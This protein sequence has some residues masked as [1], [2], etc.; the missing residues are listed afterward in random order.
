ME[1][2][3]VVIG[4]DMETK[5]FD[6]QIKATEEKL[7]S[8][9][10]EYKVLE[11]AEP[12]EGQDKALLDLQKEIEKTRNNLVDL[13][14]KQDKIDQQG[15]ANTRQSL[16]NIGNSIQKITKKITKW[17][18]AIFGI[19]SA[20]MF[21]RQS[22]GT[23]SQ[24]DD[25][26]AADVEYIRY[27]LAT[28][29]KPIIEWI[30]KGVYEILKGINYLSIAWFNYNLFQNASV[31]N[32]KKM[33]KS[34]K[35]LQKTVSSF[36]EINIL[37]GNNDTNITMPSADLSKELGMEGYKAPPW[38]E[39]IANNGEKVAA[40]AALIIGSKLLGTGLAGIASL[41][42][43]IGGSIIG[44]NLVYTALTGRDLIKDL[45]DI[46]QGIKDI[47]KS[48]EEFAKMSDEV[49]KKT[50]VALQDRRKEAEAYQLNSKEVAQYE[51]S[52][53]A[54]VDT[55][56][57]EIGTNAEFR[58]EL[59]EVL[60]SYQKLYER[61]QLNEKQIAHYADL[62]EQAGGGASDFSKQVR[63]S[64]STGQYDASFSQFANWWN[65]NIG[66]L[67]K[68]IT[69]K[70]NYSS[71][72]GGFGAYGGGS[73]GGGFRAKGGIFY[74]S[75]LPK[76]AVGGIINM[77][78]PGIPYHGAYIG[79]R[80][81]EAVVPLTDSQQMELL[82]ETIGRY[83]TVNLTNITKLDSRQIARKVDKVQQNNSFVFN[84]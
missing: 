9:I 73:G 84:R 24:Y 43:L 41:G 75:K 62:L 15:F 78:G 72:G 55:R 40:A 80:G 82:G 51:A 58:E 70:L 36:D 77:P 60:I 6:L 71:A 39:W 67:D 42:A 21:I 5:G 17:G 48:Q 8:L 30:I 28:A 10:E 32:F 1:D 31:K 3:K 65:R 12:F 64:L 57:D 74:P 59:R 53:R 37:G 63:Q 61:G 54:L 46:C 22:M 23:L 81:A 29:I 49:H 79:E 66:K 35:E 7:E 19:R 44:V 25:K 38:L 20:Y 11:K 83:I 45:Y 33:N 76:L 69:I 2:G 68:E 13:K 56:M 16:D 14:E 18:L 52:L 50:L 26:L 47:K 4:I 34:A 27:A